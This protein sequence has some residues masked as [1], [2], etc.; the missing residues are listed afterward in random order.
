MKESII[1]IIGYILSISLITI[2][3]STW[4]K[5]IKLKRK[6]NDKEN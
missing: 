5:S 4:Y 6:I 3:I 1:D 2:S